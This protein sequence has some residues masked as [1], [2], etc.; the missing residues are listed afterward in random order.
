M[1]QARA[2]WIYNVVVIE[3]SYDS[4]LSED[5]FLS[6]ATTI[7]STVAC[8]QFSIYLLLVDGRTVR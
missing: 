4:I 3:Y 7:V 8:I 1:V 5:I 2:S 6:A